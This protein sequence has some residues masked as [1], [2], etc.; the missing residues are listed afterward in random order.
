MILRSES[1]SLDFCEDIIITKRSN[2]KSPFSQMQTHG[3]AIRFSV[4]RSPSRI[5]VLSHEMGCSFIF[6]QFIEYGRQVFGSIPLTVSRIA[7][8]NTTKCVSLVK[9]AFVPSRRLSAQVHDASTS[10]TYNS[11]KLARN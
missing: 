3:H 2:K 5:T 11:T 8:M 7:S 1:H 9:R 6:I 4:A 10:I